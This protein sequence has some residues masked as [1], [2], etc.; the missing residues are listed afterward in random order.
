MELKKKI[1]IICTFGTLFLYSGNSIAGSFSLMNNNP[2]SHTYSEE[3]DNKR[4]REKRIAGYLKDNLEI[5][6]NPNDP[7]HSAFLNNLNEEGDYIFDAIGVLGASHKRKGSHRY[8]TEEKVDNLYTHIKKMEN[9]IKVRYKSTSKS[10]LDNFQSYQGVDVT[11]DCDGQIHYISDII[12]VSGHINEGIETL[13]STGYELSGEDEKLTY[14]DV[15]VIKAMAKTNLSRYESIVKI[16]RN[17]LDY[18]GAKNPDQAR[19]IMKLAGV[20]G[21]MGSIAKYFKKNQGGFTGDNGLMSENDF[22]QIL[23]KL[24]D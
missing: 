20:A 6:V 23:E 15:N 8:L 19:F 12:K 24:R 1:A 22:A 18:S 13:A 9:V 14:A 3:K 11:E 10:I 21:D 17:T 4:A 7:G 5:V 16:F 2:Q